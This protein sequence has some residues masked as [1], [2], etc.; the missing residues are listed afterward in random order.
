MTC[1]SWIEAAKKR[2]KQELGRQNCIKELVICIQYTED[3]ASTNNELMFSY[4]S[5][6]SSFWAEAVLFEFETLK[7]MSMESEQAIILLAVSKEVNE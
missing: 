4:R 7:P 1:W 2:A 5:Q 6:K 3:C